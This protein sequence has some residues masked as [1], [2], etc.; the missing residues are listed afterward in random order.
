MK[1]EQSPPVE[2]APNHR[3]TAPKDAK[4]LPPANAKPADHEEHESHWITWVLILVV[5]LIGVAAL[6][7]LGK[8]KT[9]QPPQQTV[10][11]TV[12]NVRQGDI[13]VTVEA[14]GTVTPVYTAMMSPRVDGQI[15]AVDYTEGQIVASNDLLAVIDPG[16]YQAAYLQALGQL[17]RDT[18]VLAGAQVDLERYKT[19]Y[20]TNDIHAISKQQ[21]DD[22][23]ALV[24]QDE[25]TVKLDEG[26]LAAAKVNLDYC[27]IRA[28]FPGRVGL[29]LVDP[30][31]V[32]HAANSNAVVVVAQLQPITV[33]FNVAEDYLPQI[34]EQLKG[35]HPM[36]VEA[37]DRA[38]ET[39]LA[40]GRVLALDNLIDTSTGTIKI[41]AIF[42]NKDLMLFPNQFVNAK[43][44][45]KTLRKLDL[46]PTYAVQQN[47]EGAF[48]YLVTNKPPTN[49]NRPPGGAQAGASEAAAG[50]MGGGGGGGHAR[51]GGAGASNGPPMNIA[52]VTMRNIKTGPADNDVTAIMDGLEPGESI[53]IDN[54]NKLG[55]GVKIASQS[56]GQAE[57]GG[58]GHHRA[59][60]SYGQKTESGDTNN[61]SKA[62]P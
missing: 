33:E 29:R 49:T 59:A 25:G 61:D 34:Q 46:I 20:F 17:Q 37:W 1:T 35:G 39:K 60:G 8:K 30:G 11:V 48:V 41:R 16:P 10:T 14:L 57:S 38:L 28:P 47:P 3:L 21:Y 58:S 26:Q 13:N 4:A 12:T 24:N 45:I 36:T 15:I 2:T 52:W 6:I 5:V 44:I 40:T 32:V 50:E 19:A 27:Y 43:V 22:Q 54:F 53:A 23:V 42:D 51:D 56:H 18:N 9:R 7:L 55:E 62:G 31:N